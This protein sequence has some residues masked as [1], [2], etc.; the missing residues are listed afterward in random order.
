MVPLLGWIALAGALG[1]LSRFGLSRLVQ[2]VCGDFP[3]HTFVVNALGCLLFGV[4]Y[5]VGSGRWPSHVSA[6]ILVGFFGAFTTFSSFAFDCQQLLLERR[7]WQLFGNV[8]VQNV[9]G[10]AAMLGGIGLADWLRG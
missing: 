6:A 2:G 5:A 7:L 10:L 3:L 1:S 8:A 9:L 4:V